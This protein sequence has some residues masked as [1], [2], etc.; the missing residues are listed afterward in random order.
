MKNLFIRTINCLLI[1]ATAITIFFLTKQSIFATNSYPVPSP[2]VECNKTEKPEWH[3]LRPYQASPCEA[4][5]KEEEQSLLCGNTIFINDTIKHPKDPH[6]C[7][8]CLPPPCCGCVIDRNFKA[9]REFIVAFN[10]FESELPIAGNTELIPSGKT[11]SLGEKE[12]RLTDWKNH[13]PPDPSNY[14]TLQ[15][16]YKKYQEWR[17]RTCA[18]FRI[19][20]IRTTVFFCFNDP[21][22]PDYWAALFPYI[23]YSSTEDRIGKAH[24]YDMIYRGGSVDYI[25]PNPPDTRWNPSLNPSDPRHQK[26]KD[27]E[28]PLYFPHMEENNELMSLLQSTYLAEALRK[29]KQEIKDTEPVQIGASCKILDVRYNPGDQLFGEKKD[30]LG[31]PNANVTYDAYYH[32]PVLY[33]PPDPI[34][35]TCYYYIELP[36]TKNARFSSDVDTYTPMIEELF[37]KTVAGNMSF[38]RRIFP[39]LGPGNPVEK[40]KD[41]PASTQVI[42]QSKDVVSHTSV[43]S[44]PAEFYI[45]H[46]GSVYDYFLMGIQSVL[47]PKGFPG[48]PAGLSK[49][50]AI[51]EA[52]RA[53]EYLSW[54][55][56]GT[57]FRAESDP[58]S[59]KDEKD[60]KRLTTFSGP[61]NK[62]LPQE[63]QWR[64]KITSDVLNSQRD[65]TQKT[66]RVDEVTP[67]A[68]KDRHDQIV[69]C[70]KE[71][72]LLG[73]IP[74]WMPI[75]GGGITIGGIPTACSE[76]S[77]ASVGQ[78]LGNGSPSPTPGH[79]G[80]PNV[81]DSQ[82]EPKYLGNMKDNF[83]RMAATYGGCDLVDECYNYVVSES[84]KAGVNPALTLTLWLH[85]SGASSYCTNPGVE[86]FGVHYI[87]GEDIVGQ[88]QEWLK[89]GKSGS[90]CNWCYNQ[91]PNQWKEPMQAFLYVY[92]YG[93][94]DCNPSGNQSFYEDMVKMFQWVSDPIAYCLDSGGGFKISCS[95]DMSCP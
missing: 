57:L 60:I 26:I 52:D 41:I 84:K 14:K 32:C 79:S 42:H 74:D 61:L 95:N 45:P 94:G 31:I 9:S 23:P 43:E 67:R 53:N 64:N 29:E 72:T 83:R 77:I 25:D 27:N 20:I 21:S 66:G 5:I 86:D 75:I 12:K 44:M 71:I 16:Y 1:L 88:L 46:L 54:Y 8:D 87:P 91:Y 80:C 93:A 15:D 55:L 76:K 17:G 37:S 7:L 28:T 36:C 48:Q 65:K 2:Y 18:E 22:K 51:P 39:S 85:E 49:N 81:P 63:I 50:Q 58:L 3:S 24:V 69:A 47:R 19:P 13:L 34:T 4:P 40:I 6:T 11:S 89:I 90:A 56:N 62:L 35:G 78:N 59:H 30:D 82:V 73:W 70:T 33:P 68:K 38:F 10:A 92:R